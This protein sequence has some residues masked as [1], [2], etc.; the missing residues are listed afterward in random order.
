[1]TRTCGFRTRILGQ[2]PRRGSQ[3]GRHE[4]TVGCLRIGPS[5][6]AGPGRKQRIVGHP[7]QAIAAAEIAGTARPYPG[8][9]ASW[10][11]R[12]EPRGPVGASGSDRFRISC[13]ENSLGASGSGSLGSLGE[14]RG[15]TDWEPRGQTDL[16]S[17]GVGEPRG[18]SG[19]GEPRGEPRGRGASGSGSLG[20]RPI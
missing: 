10:E 6:L 12:W 17:L 15:Q 1:M 11:P 7:V 2:A 4:A 3:T 19:S 20:V 14:P 9:G 18:A 13:G 8:L 5:E 16:G